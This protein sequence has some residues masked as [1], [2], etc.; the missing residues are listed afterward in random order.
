MPNGFVCWSPA[1]LEMIKSNVGELL[2]ED[3][4][5]LAATHEP[6]FVSAK[7]EGQPRQHFETWVDNNSPSIDNDLMAAINKTIADPNQLQNNLLIAV[8][9]VTGSGKSHLVRWLYQN[10]IQLEN[11]RTVWVIRREDSKMQV[12]RKFV[13]DLVELGSTKAGRLKVLIDKS[14]K[15]VL[16]DEEKLVA[17]LYNEVSTELRFNK[18]LI[19]GKKGEEI[20]RLILGSNES[21]P[22]LHNLLYKYQNEELETLPNDGFSFIINH[23]VKQLAH[24]AKPDE[25]IETRNEQISFT[26]DSTRKI[27]RRYQKKVDKEFNELLQIS[28]T[29]ISLVTEILNEALDIAVSKVMHIEGGGFTEIFAELREEMRRLN[30]QLVIFMEDFSGVATSQKGLSKLQVDLLSVF[31]EEVGPE[32]APLRVI[33]AITNNTWDVIPTNVKARHTLVVDIDRAFER[34]DSESFLSRYLNISRASRE[35]IIEAYRDTDPI[36]R[37]DAK[38]VPNKCDQCPYRIDCHDTFGSTTDGVGLYPINIVAGRR[39]FGKTPTEPRDIVQRL[40]GLLLSSQYS[41]PKNEFPLAQ[42]TKNYLIK[43][44]R[45]ESEM[46]QIKFVNSAVNEAESHRLARYV[47]IWKAGVLPNENEMRIFNFAELGAM[48]GEKSVVLHPIS[49]TDPVPPRPI[50][51]PEYDAVALWVSAPSDILSAEKLTNT[52]HSKIRS[53]ISNLVEENLDSVYGNWTDHKSFTGIKFGAPS[54]RVVG[55]S[56]KELDAKVPSGADLFPFYSIPRNEYGRI[57]LMG[58]LIENSRRKSEPSGLNAAEEAEYRIFLADFVLSVTHSI[59]EK[60]SSIK[61][62]INGPLGVI[63]K[64][65]KIA[66]VLDPDKECSDEMQ[67]IGKWIANTDVSTISTHLPDD[68]VNRLL[69]NFG[70]LKSVFLSLTMV[71][72]GETENSRFRDVFLVDKFMR[73]L[74]NSP[75]ELIDSLFTPHEWWNADERLIPE[76]YAKLIDDNKTSVIDNLSNSAIVE[77]HNRLI[78][79]CDNINELLGNELQFDSSEVKELISQM[80]INSNLSVTKQE[81]NESVDRIKDTIGI[82]PQMRDQLKEVTVANPNSDTYFL[83]RRLSS[84]LQNQIDSVLLLFDSITRATHQIKNTLGEVRGIQ[85]EVP[86]DMRKLTSADGFELASEG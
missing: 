37:K 36:T 52:I 75:T 65:L 83:N 41:I 51:N 78:D 82:W 80:L 16:D 29:N 17:Q 84:D 6:M 10:V 27:L 19:S 11:T 76:W 58:A 38:W 43:D 25:T 54:I 33:Y 30:Q 46:V 77:W 13:D 86:F 70:R 48:V 55:F 26:D 57:V 35:M 4:S 1:G 60:V 47:H 74:S 14:F 2:N 50:R 79:N 63:S 18:S 81:L 61:G 39:L 8:K 68:A 42:V 7:I 21:K 49:N 28:Q 67:I 69:I 44:D 45:D 9:G 23:V 85:L 64:A 24:D 72:M 12:I 5:I 53:V 32:R 40:L 3:N 34:T 73:E 31:T 59:M 62:S 20:R 56:A 22:R 66:E 15:D 71:S